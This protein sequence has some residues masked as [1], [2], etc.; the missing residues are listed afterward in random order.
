MSTKDELFD[1]FMNINRQLAMIRHKAEHRHGPL[2]NATRGQ[3]RV[4]ALLKLH[5][6]V[7]ARQM[8]EI[9]GIRVSSLNEMLS[10]MEAQD[11]I[12]RV[13]S[14]D[15]KRVML[16]MLTDAGRAVEQDQ[17]D[18]PDR[19]F[20]AFSADERA[21]LAEYFERIVAR[22]G[23]DLDD[24]DYERFEAMRAHHAEFASHGHRKRHGHPG[25]CRPPQS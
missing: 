25:A 20:G 13:P 12:A 24:E 3:G 9:L 22:L 8:A 18:I 5:D 23:E 2:G 4:L 1:Q 11:L 19:L 21:Q 7:S 6:G 14:E 10:K 17:P 16:V 15:D